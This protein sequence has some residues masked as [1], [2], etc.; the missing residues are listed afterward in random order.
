MRLL[1][2]FNLLDDM[3]A[4]RRYSDT[5]MIKPESNL[6][7]V[8]FVCMMSSFIAM[9]MKKNG[10]EIDFELLFHKLSIHDAD[11]TV[12]G[13]ILRPTKYFDEDIKREIDRVAGLC[14]ESVA[15]QIGYPEY[16]RMWEMA[17]EG[18][19]GT[20]VAVA[21]AFAVLWRARMEVF[22]F[23]NNMMMK[24]VKGLPAYMASLKGRVVEHFGERTPLQSAIDSAIMLAV[25]LKT[26]E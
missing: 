10:H 4:V 8:G 23:G 18:K 20:I 25:Q 21:D 5:H 7:H 24:N 6:E 13:D 15:D 16:H 17:K 14:M 2:I 11:E 12:T 9:E 26:G 3:S 22:G 1:T 19:E